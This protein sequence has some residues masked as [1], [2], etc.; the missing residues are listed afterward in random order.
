MWQR[1]KPLLDSQSS[2]QWWTS[3]S[4]KWYTK[5]NLLKLRW[6]AFWN[7]KLAHQRRQPWYGAPT[8]EATCPVCHRGLDGAGHIL[9]G[10]EHPELRAI[11]ISRHNQAVQIIHRAVAKG[12]C[13]NLHCIMD[14]GK[15]AELPS[16]A[17]STRLPHW[18][19]PHHVAPSL[20]KKMRPDLAYIDKRQDGTYAVDLIEVG[21]CGD[22][23]HPEKVAEK[24]QQHAQLTT[25]L[26]EAGHMV[27]PHTVT[28]GH[29]GT[30]PSSTQHCLRAM[31]VSQEQ[32]RRTLS[33]LNTLAA[34]SVEG[35]VMRRRQL[36]RDLSTAH[37]CPVC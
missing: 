16:S 32:V 1:T 6:G 8:R 22:H 36:E 21:Y 15:A 37:A 29:T 11:Y 30:I 2:N 19:R 18:L 17:Q 10:C 3:S 23:N 24:L 28:L 20:W 31:G 14:A 26:K 13:G 4:I 35:I 34:T 7:K 27:R 5:A 33:K 25:L 9:G 12:A